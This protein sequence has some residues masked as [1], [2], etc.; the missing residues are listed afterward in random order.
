MPI[1]NLYACSMPAM[2]I[3]CLAMPILN[4]YACSMPAMPIICLAMPILCR[5]MSTM[6]ILC[7]RCQ[8]T[9]WGVNMEANENQYFNLMIIHLTIYR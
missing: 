3:L 1:L 7:V 2:L 9:G 8:F 6:P 5:N 4:L